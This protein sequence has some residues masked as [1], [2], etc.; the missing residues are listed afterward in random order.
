MISCSERKRT[1]FVTSYALMY[2]SSK[3]ILLIHS[4][5]PE[6]TGEK[7][8]AFR[9]ESKSNLWCFL[10]F[11]LDIQQWLQRVRPHEYKHSFFKLDVYFLY[12]FQGHKVLLIL[13]KVLQQVFWS[14]VCTA[15]LVCFKHQQGCGTHCAL[16]ANLHLK[17]LLLFISSF[18]L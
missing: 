7:L 9:T 5:P 17:V 15:A 12:G 3:V 11:Y 10:W 16:I 18:C 4:V 8:F 6:R 13:R 2:V 14:A 1:S